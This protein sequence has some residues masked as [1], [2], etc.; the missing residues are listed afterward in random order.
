[1]VGNAPRDLLDPRLRCRG[2]A[3]AGRV[4]ARAVER[5]RKAPQI[6][7][8]DGC[9]ACGI[10]VA[11]AVGQTQMKSDDTAHR[12]RPLAAPSCSVLLRPAPSCSVLL[13]PAPSCS[14]LL[15]P[16]PSCS[17]LLRPAPSRSVLLR[18]KTKRPVSPDRS[19]SRIH[20]SFAI[21]AAGDVAAPFAIHTHRTTLARGGARGAARNYQDHTKRPEFPAQEHGQRDAVPFPITRRST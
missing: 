17:V 9:R 10:V 11:S 5:A 21:S 3:V 19:P 12:S 15:R 8:L 6:R 4:G 18:R 2:G 14:V 1:M 16:A 13:R 7:V 20:H